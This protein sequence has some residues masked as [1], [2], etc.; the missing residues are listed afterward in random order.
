MGQMQHLYG[1]T[2][3]PETVKAGPPWVLG[4]LWSVSISN[5]LFCCMLKFTGSFRDHVVLLGLKNMV[6]RGL[7]I[8]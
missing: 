6:P 3:K 5:I 7:G 4:V 2:G 8:L 1:V